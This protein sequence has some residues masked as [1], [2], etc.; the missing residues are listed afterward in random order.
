MDER[1]KG[2]MKTDLGR[3]W[4]QTCGMWDVF[5]YVMP[6]CEAMYLRDAKRREEDK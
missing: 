2:F 4:R 5:A 6:R 3:C 1:L